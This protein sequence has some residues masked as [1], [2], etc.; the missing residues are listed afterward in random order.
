MPEQ[1]WQRSLGDAL[2]A[3]LQ[4][5]AGRDRYAR[6]QM[7]ATRGGA[8]PPGRAH[9]LEFDESGFPLPQ[10]KPGFAMR[11]ARLLNPF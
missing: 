11:V 5:Q 1:A 10:D 3:A 2:E 7:Q 6:A 8:Y 4:E 9:P